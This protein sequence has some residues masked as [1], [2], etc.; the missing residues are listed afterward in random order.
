MEKKYQIFISSTYEDLKE[1]RQ[2]VINAI[3]KMYH[4]PIG[5]E[6]FSADDTA[7]WEV[8]RKTIDV[9]DYYIL[10]IG[11]RYGSETQE[12][13]SFTEKEY[14]YAVEKKIPILAFIKDRNCSTSK[15]ERDE[16]QDKVNNLICKVQKMRETWKNIDELSY[17]VAASLYKQF[18]T[19]PQKGWVR[20]EIFTD[21]AIDNDNDNDNDNE[22]RY[23][24][25]WISKEDINNMV[26]IEGMSTEI[27]EKTIRIECS[28]RNTSEKTFMTITG[29]ISF[30]N[31]NNEVYKVESCIF[32]ANCLL[33]PCQSNACKFE[34]NK[35]YYP[36]L[37]NDFKFA[38][39]EIQDIFDS[40]VN[41]YVC[42]Y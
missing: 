14:D 9:S 19:N 42:K 30:Y 32:L 17:K 38:E 35:D 36:Q 40:N 27:S 18:V 13:I 39:I 21:A 1:A 34:F 10:I 26:K 12:G 23:L 22:G 15:S 5:M 33:K 37:L 29:T 25:H 6:M 4:I 24:K 3:L 20:N 31:S 28:I 41:T 7:Q 2:S 8:I 11:F 16:N